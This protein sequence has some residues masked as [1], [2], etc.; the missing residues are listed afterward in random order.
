MEYENSYCVQTDD[1]GSVA[2]IDYSINICM[3]LLESYAC[4]TAKS[5][6]SVME[7]A[8]AKRAMATYAPAETAELIDSTNELLEMVERIRNLRKKR[9]MIPM[10]TMH[11]HPSQ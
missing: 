5:I 9:A 2:R 4:Q 6:Q 1:A 7:R 11:V 10:G 8:V 3:L